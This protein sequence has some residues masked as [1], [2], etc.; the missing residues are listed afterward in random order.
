MFCM[1]H[2]GDDDSSNPLRDLIAD[3]FSTL[4]KRYP[5]KMAFVWVEGTKQMVRVGILPGDFHNGTL[6]PS[7]LRELVWRVE[8]TNAYL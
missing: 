3:E 5:Y 6:P 1:V 7:V 4:S 2:N 8:S